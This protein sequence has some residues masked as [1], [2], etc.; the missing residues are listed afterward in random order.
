MDSSSALGSCGLRGDVQGGSQVVRRD[1]P[2]LTIGFQNKLLGD[3]PAGLLR[4]SLGLSGVDVGLQYVADEAGL[5][6]HTV[7]G[8]VY[9]RHGG[10]GVQLVAVAGLGDLDLGAV[11][12]YAGLA[13][14]VVY[15]RGDLPDLGPR[16]GRPVVDVGGYGHPAE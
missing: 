8:T 15:L 1:R 14:L 11:D 4:R 7:D 3:G 2:A 9:A 12:L 6:A 10:G 5:A 13:R 16:L